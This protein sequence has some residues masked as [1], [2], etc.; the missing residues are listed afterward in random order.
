M[1]LW[2]NYRFGLIPH[3]RM[4]IRGRVDLR[5]GRQLETW[6]WGL[7]ESFPDVCWINARDVKLNIELASLD[8]VYPD[9]AEV[10]SHGRIYLAAKHGYIGPVDIEWP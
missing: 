7:P 6:L 2:L 10:P 9:K 4:E 5:N 8:V 1:A 3:N